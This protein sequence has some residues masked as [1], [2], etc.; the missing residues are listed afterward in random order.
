MF[1][2]VLD[3]KLAY[4]YLLYSCHNTYL[5]LIHY[6]SKFVRVLTFSVSFTHGSPTQ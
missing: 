5:S 2:I 4:L 6:H 3:M 1:I